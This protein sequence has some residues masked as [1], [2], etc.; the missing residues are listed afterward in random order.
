MKLFNLKENADFGN[1]SAG[2]MTCS[3]YFFLIQN[4]LVPRYTYICLKNFPI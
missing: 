3:V 4:E 2:L 1:E